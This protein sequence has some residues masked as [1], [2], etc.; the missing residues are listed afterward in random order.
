MGIS[1][2]SIE[3]NQF[4]PASLSREEL[5][6]GNEM[7]Y[8]IILKAKEMAHKNAS[9]MAHYRTESSKKLLP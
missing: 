5:A 2:N 6:I 9:Q 7:G 1:K 3:E 4:T 8:K